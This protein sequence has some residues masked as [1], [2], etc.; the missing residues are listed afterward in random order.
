M[1]LA[2]LHAVPIVAEASHSCREDEEQGPLVRLSSYEREQVALLRRHVHAA[3][4][5]AEAIANA[6]SPL[7]MS[8]SLQVLCWSTESLQPDLKALEHLL[9][10][11]RCSISGGS[12]VVR[13]VHRCTH[14]LG[15]SDGGC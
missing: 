12:S 5:L 15:S 9:I 7:A 10:H 4:T 6:A 2:P 14:N 11:L 1:C 8:A 3:G 13:S